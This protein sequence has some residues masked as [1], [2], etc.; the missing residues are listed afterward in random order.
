MQPIKLGIPP[1][2]CYSVQVLGTKCIGGEKNHK[3]NMCTRHNIKFW[4]ETEKDLWDSH[5]L[6]IG[7]IGHGYISSSNSLNWCI[8]IF[9]AF[10]NN[11][12]AAKK[13]SV[14]TKSPYPH[15]CANACGERAYHISAPI[16][17]CGKLSS[18]VT[19]LFVFLTD[20]LIVALSSGLIERR[21]ITY[22]QIAVKNKETFAVC[23]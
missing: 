1:K 6:E 10:L 15:R 7:S 21:F 2:Q 4:I 22:W 20:A 13:T 12:H 5:P 14:R 23:G 18:M 17:C 11:R 16:P 8:K 3:Q 19:N 9:K